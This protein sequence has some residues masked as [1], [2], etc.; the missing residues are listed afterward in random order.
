[1]EPPPRWKLKSPA[2]VAPGPS[3]PRDG[4]LAAYT[5]SHALYR[6]IVKMSA[7]VDTDRVVFRNAFLS[8]VKMRLSTVLL[9]VPA[10]DRR[11]LFQARQVRQAMRDA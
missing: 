2:P 5:M 7:E 11:H 8:R 1:M 10:H 9:I 6:A 3:F 4:L